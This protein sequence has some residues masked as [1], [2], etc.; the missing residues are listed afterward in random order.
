[1]VA[2]G[3]KLYAIGGNDGRKNVG[4]VEAYDP[5]TGKWEKRKGMRVP[6]CSS[7]AAVLNGRIYV[8][9]GSRD[10]WNGPVLKLVESYDPAADA[11]TVEAGM[12]AYRTAGGAATA[13][14]GIC[15]I[16]GVDWVGGKHL[17]VT[18]CFYPGGEAWLAKTA[19]KADVVTVF[20]GIAM[21]MAI[22]GGF[23][24]ALV[25]WFV[26]RRG[27]H[28][29]VGRS[30]ARKPVLHRADKSR[31]EY[32]FAFRGRGGTLFGIKILNIAKNIVTLG[33]YSFW[34]RV[35]VRNYV[36]GAMAVGGD[37]LAYHGT[38][39]E[40]FRGFLKACVV[41]I[42]P[43]SALHH[44]P[45]LLSAPSWV[46][47]TC[48]IAT[49]ALL[50]LFIPL[51]TV[52]MQRY[53]LS[54]TSLRNIRFSYLGKWWPYAKLFWGT[55]ALSILTL[56]FYSP[57]SSVWRHQFHVEWTRYGSGRFK[58]TGSGLDLMGPYLLAL[59]L[60]IPTI[61]LSM[62][63]YGIYRQRYF[64]NKTRFETAQF[65]STIRF[66]SLLWIKAT[67]IMLVVLTLGLGKA[68][69]TVRYYRYLQDNL[70]LAGRLDLAGILQQPVKGTPVGDELADYLD[71]NM[72]LG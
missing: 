21:I 31:T 32:R 20:A 10:R 40:L 47:T 48:V 60:A 71:I 28:G 7:G 67:N 41:F 18:D 39:L 57:F 3:G 5:G 23:V 62:V 44:L 4:A 51:A 34:G 42:I 30:A 13:G 19:R 36:W 61:F 15:L 55:M 58:F 43:Y 54:R 12:P 66:L 59:L 70:L 53:R 65:R 64:W 27:K 69:A 14:N 17:A 22:V 45:A 37:R 52:G 46:K 49:F 11:W 38:G 8:F 24:L 6:R 9:G 2:A 63:W 35:R 33:V 16:G 68:W 25:L 29:K 1:L 72:D 56:G 26:L 50:A